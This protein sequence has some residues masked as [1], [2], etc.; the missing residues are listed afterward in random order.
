MIGRDLCS[1]RQIVATWVV[2]VLSWG[3][4]RS[5]S[6]RGCPYL[7]CTCDRLLLE[8]SAGAETCTANGELEPR[9]KMPL[10]ALT[11]VN[12]A[13]GSQHCHSGNASAISQN[14]NF[15]KM[16]GW[17]GRTGEAASR[18][19][20]VLRRP[21][22]PVPHIPTFGRPSSNGACRRPQDPIGDATMEAADGHR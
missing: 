14:H 17:H 2:Q 4:F 8:H 1:N 21:P 9:A 7:N 5:S 19:L 13:G 16:L 6:T 15:F 22:A 18:P 20:N 12:R 11:V 10:A 3:R